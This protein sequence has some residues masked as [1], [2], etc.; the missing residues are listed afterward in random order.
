MKKENPSQP[1]ITQK[2]EELGLNL[3]I[4]EDKTGQKHYVFKNSKEFIM[5]TGATS[6]RA[7]DI[8]DK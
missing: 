6:H 2:I 7:V 3:N 1:M 8:S 5:M 4:I